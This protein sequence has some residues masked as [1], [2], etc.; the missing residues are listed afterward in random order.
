MPKQK[1]VVDPNEFLADATVGLAKLD[2]TQRQCVGCKD[3][4]VLVNGHDDRI[5]A[6]EIWQEAEA[7]KR[8]VA[9][10]IAI[11]E[12]AE[13]MAANQASL[14]KWRA[15]E[16]RRIARVRIATKTVLWSALVVV[17][18]CLLSIIP[19]VAYS[20]SGD[21]FVAGWRDGLLYIG[22]FLFFGGIAVS[23]VVGSCLL[24][25]RI[26]QWIDSASKKFATRRA[27]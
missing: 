18:V 1:K 15:K 19:A 24:V 21:G 8:A 6:I 11:S 5:R 3:L 2:E 12:R 9:E 7:E 4:R 16:A 13:R 26:L 27:S 20:A 17:G 23:L 14:D 25:A 10:K 22:G